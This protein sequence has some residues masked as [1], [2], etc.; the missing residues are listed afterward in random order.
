MGYAREGREI[1][2]ISMR[3]RKS[4]LTKRAITQQ[5]SIEREGRWNGSVQLPLP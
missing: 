2:S 1:S 3:V 5:F 4:G